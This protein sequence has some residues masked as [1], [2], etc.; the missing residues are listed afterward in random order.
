M[1]RTNSKQLYSKAGSENLSADSDNNRRELFRITLPK[2]Y[3]AV[4][5]TPGK[6]PS[7]IVDIA[8]FGI[9]CEN[10]AHW[11]TIDLNR[12]ID[13]TITFPD[14]ESLD[15]RGEIVRVTNFDYALR[16]PKGI[17]L[18]KMMEIQRDLIKR[19]NVTEF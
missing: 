16:I 11:E 4:C 15:Y 6:D 13:F 10:G 17:P 1:E 8:E 7:L 2:G 9:R 14:G 12:V 19:F 5:T 3:V 18:S